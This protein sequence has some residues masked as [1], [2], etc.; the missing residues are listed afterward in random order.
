VPLILSYSRPICRRHPG[1]R[2]AREEKFWGRNISLKS[3]FD[4]KGR[5]IGFP[6]HLEPAGW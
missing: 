1:P 5:P 6:Q 3:K 4:Q 2:I